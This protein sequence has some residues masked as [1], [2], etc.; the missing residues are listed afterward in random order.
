MEVL[1]KVI[2]NHSSIGRAKIF[3]QLYELVFPVVARF[4]SKMGGS[5]DDAKDIFQDALVIYYEKKADPDFTISISQEAY[6]MGISK[7]LWL[8]KFNKN[9]RYVSLDDDDKEISIP[10]DYF[11]DPNSA[12]LLKF[13]ERAGKKCMDLLR[14]FYYEKLS[15]KQLAQTM[16]YSTERSATVQKYKCLEKVRDTIKQKS[17]GYEDFIE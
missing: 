12:L 3:E 16:G 14:A 5:L 9:N 10:A 6:I 7:H 17:I 4:V 13:L 1:E 2:I 8:R 15:M 11:P